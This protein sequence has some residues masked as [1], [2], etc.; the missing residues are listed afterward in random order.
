MNGEKDSDG[1]EVE[2]EG[3]LL[4]VFCWIIITAGVAGGLYNEKVCDI[5]QM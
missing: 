1:V 5:A 4:W 3:L 2:G